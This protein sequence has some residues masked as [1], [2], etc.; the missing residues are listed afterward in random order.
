MTERDQDR[1]EGREPID[2]EAAWAQIVAAYGDEPPDPPGVWPEAADKD[3]IDIVDRTALNGLNGSGAGAGPGGAAGQAAEEERRRARERPDA[4]PEGLGR[5]PEDRQW[6]RT[7]A[8]GPGGRETADG[9][10][11]GDAEDDGD[12]R[13]DGGHDGPWEGPGPR[14]W[15]P[16]DE[17]EGHFEPPEPPP[18]PATDMTTRFAWTAVLGGP[19][20]L[21]L[22]A[23]LGQPMTWWI[24]TL[25]VGG[26]LGG[27]ATLVARMRD[28]RDDWPD[29]GGGAVV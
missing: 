2:E 3:R 25:G 13:D 19:L 27:F 21:V 15:A 20:L 12:D 22:T 29:P 10:D 28:G 14:D 5:E 1:G 11:H 6:D 26:F 4:G 7:D 8:E 23:M 16:E 9:R 17:D 24:T 18:L